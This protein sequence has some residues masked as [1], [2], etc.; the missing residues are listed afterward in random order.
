M[1]MRTVQGVGS[2]IGTVPVCGLL[3]V[4][5]DSGVYFECDRS[6]VEPLAKP[7]RAPF[8]G[9]P[10]SAVVVTL[11][12]VRGVLECYS[13]DGKRACVLLSRVPT[14]FD[15]RELEAE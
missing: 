15:A 12:G 6:D 13:A 3:C 2:V 11:S 5:L 7:D 1:R 9:R 10:G 8:D 4:R 14:W